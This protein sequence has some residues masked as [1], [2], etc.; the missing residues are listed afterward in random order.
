MSPFAMEYFGKEIF[1]ILAC[2][3]NL[4]SGILKNN[5]YFMEVKQI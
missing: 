3:T 1:V 4:M 5:L 2:R